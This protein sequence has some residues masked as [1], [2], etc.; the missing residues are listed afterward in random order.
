[1]GLS[2]QVM[3]Y[4]FEGQVV[5]KKGAK[6]EGEVFTRVKIKVNGSEPQYYKGNG[7]TL[8]TAL[9]DSLFSALTQ[10]CKALKGLRFGHLQVSAMSGEN[11]MAA[12]AAV[13][14]HFF[15]MQGGANGCKTS[16]TSQD[17]VDSSFDC[18]CQAVQ[19]YINLLT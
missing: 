19:N 13:Q 4:T 6:S 15:L 3:G 5:R 18:L 2:F 17:L 1:M 9:S 10:H 7:E 14:V 8:I 12:Q 16:H 11:T